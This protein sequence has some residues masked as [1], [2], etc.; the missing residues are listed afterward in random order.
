[1]KTN[2]SKDGSPITEAYRTASRRILFLDYD[3][4][5]VPFND[6]PGKSKLPPQVRDLLGI[7]AN[8]SRN[9]IFII[10]GR[11]REFLD[12]Q[13]RGLGVGLVAEHG[14]RYREPGRKW[15]P[16]GPLSTGWRIPILETFRELTGRFPGSFIEEKESSVAY[17][18]RTAGVHIEQKVLPVI[19]ESFGEIHKRYTDLEKLEGHKIVEIKSRLYNKGSIASELASREP[20]DF[21]LAAGDDVTD[22]TL[23]TG[24]APDAFTIKIGSPKTSAR[25]RTGNPEGFIDF[26]GELTRAV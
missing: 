7:L 15:S 19:R 5:L 2:L 26:L 17:H 22:E 9:M 24:L 25:F 8:D 14:Y 4:T 20:Y 23:F 3:G 13:F 18:F 11:A 21:I 16:G 10:S 1:M 12:R 6:R